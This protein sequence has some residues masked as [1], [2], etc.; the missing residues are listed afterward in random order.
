MKA[1]IILPIVGFL[2]GLG[3]LIIGLFG[4]LIVVDPE[5]LSVFKQ[6]LWTLQG[7]GFMGVNYYLGKIIYEL[8]F[9]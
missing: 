7:L 8:D 6:V 5:N 3:L 1:F 4:R 9:K 2:C